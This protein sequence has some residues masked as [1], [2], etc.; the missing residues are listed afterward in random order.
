[1]RPTLEGRIQA[2]RQV[3]DAFLALDGIVDVDWRVED[4]QPKYVLA[5]DREKASLSGINDTDIVN[6][7]AVTIGGR[8]AGLLHSDDDREEVPINVRL[9]RAG[10]SD[11]GKIN[12]LKLR[13]PG[14]ELVALGDLVK[15]EWKVENRSIN[16]K[17]LLP[18]TY[19]TAEVADATRARSTRCST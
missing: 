6:T 4:D 9:S 1:M 8:S 14:Q 15:P 2:A 7:L 10:R 5:L 19:V 13:G 3:R 17:N 16:H 11:L 18:V 12:E